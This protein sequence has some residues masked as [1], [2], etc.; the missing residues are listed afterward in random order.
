MID[1]YVINLK[2]RIDRLERVKKDFANYNLIIIEAIENDEGWKGCFKSHL[3]CIEYAKNNNL[4]YIIVI[5]DDC[6]KSIDFD[7]NIILILE[8][9]SNNLN[10]WNIFLGGVTKVWNYNKLINLR[11]NLN[12]LYISEG[13]TSH[14]I[15]YN[16]NSYDFYLNFDSSNLNI[17]IDKCWHHK[18]TA[19]TSIPFIAT[20][21]EDYSN[22]EN[23]LMNYDSR[24]NNIEK[25]FISIIKNKC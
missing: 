12:L 1:I 11:E 9:L 20:Q 5:E 22:I 3:K 13:K 16:S 18:L 15:I 21:Y 17:T 4:K 10:N 24:F 14:F 2:K 23:S 6:K 25:N 19:I 8:Y 7:S